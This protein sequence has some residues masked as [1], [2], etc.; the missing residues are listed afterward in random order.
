MEGDPSSTRSKGYYLQ[1]FSNLAFDCLREFHE[2]REL[3]DVVLCVE[4][5]RIPAHRVILAAC[6]PYFRAMFSGKMVESFKKEIVLCDL[7]GKA[8]GQI[9][10]FFYTGKIDIDEENVQ[11]LLYAAC[12]LAVS[13]VKQYCCDFLEQEICII[14]CLGIRA[15]ADTLSCT[16]LFA[17]ADSYVAANF[18]QVLLCEEFIL[19]PYE[20]IVTLIERDYLGISGETELLDGVMK[21]LH[22]DSANRGRFAYNLF[23]R[24]HLMQVGVEHLQGLLDDSVLATQPE[25]I[26]LLLEQIE[27][28][29][30]KSVVSAYEFPMFMNRKYG[31]AKEVLLAIGGESAGVFLD[32]VECLDFDIMK[33]NWTISAD[34]TEPVTLPALCQHHNYAS[35]SSTG[36][37]VYVV[38]GSSSWKALDIVQQYDWP[39]NKWLKIS[40]LNHGRLGA[41]SAIVDGQLLAVGGCGRKGY[42]SSV[43][44]YDPLVDKWSITASMKLRRSYLGVAELNGYVYAVGGYGG[45][46]DENNC[47]LSSVE[48]YIPSNDTWVPTSSMLQPRAY[49]GLVAERGKSVLVLL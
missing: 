4:E 6:S 12:L 32:S 11:S 7:N 34:D 41:G 44:A 29:G 24:L 5:R 31:K 46:A 18:S 28:L 36:R 10:D 39:D 20:S 38:G 30:S 43:E 40:S 26:E 37:H 2:N 8:L 33:W 22:W 13:S 3:C 17:V 1:D 19:Q 35:T 21:W 14:N 42:L 48:C 49:F 47:W 16:E 25:C 23:K 27:A 15:I 9:V 45:A